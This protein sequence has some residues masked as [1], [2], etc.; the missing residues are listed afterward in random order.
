MSSWAKGYWEKSTARE[1]AREYDIYSKQHSTYVKTSKKLISLSGISHCQVVIDLGVG[2]GIATKYLLKHSRQVERVYCVDFSKEMLS[3]AKRNINDKKAK[4]VLCKA[5][6]ISRHIPEKADGIISNAVFQYVDLDQVLRESNKILS[7]RGIIT[8]NIWP[9]WFKEV[10]QNKR[11]A[12][13]FEIFYR[14]MNAIAREKGFKSSFDYRFEL[15]S[16]SVFSAKSVLSSLSKNGFKLLKYQN[17]SIDRSPK[18]ILDFLKLQII[19]KHRLPNIPQPT[20]EKIL[21]EAMERT[22]K[23]F[24]NRSVTHKWP[25]FVAQAKQGIK[26]ANKF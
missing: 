25:Y 10:K 14:N 17:I 5:E 11:T 26:L 6:E 23:K 18:E 21:D 22:I 15:G 20:R 19:A 2:T 16:R 8:F 1:I 4:F 9:S 3:I 7:S 12:L 13:F 24:G